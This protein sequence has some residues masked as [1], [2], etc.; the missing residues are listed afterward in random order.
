MP[1]AEMSLLDE[2][3]GAAPWEQDGALWPWLGRFLWSPALD[4]HPTRR[5]RLLPGWPPEVWSD[6]AVCAHI[7]RHLLRALDLLDTDP[8]GASLNRNSGGFVVALLPQAPLAR[9]A[10]YTG[11]ALRGPAVLDDGT[12]LNEDERSF[13]SQ[14]LPL[15]WH[16]PDAR[17]GVPENTPSGMPANPRSG[18]PGSPVSGAPESAASGTPENAG[19]QA[20]T[21]ILGPQ[22]EEITRRFEWKTPT[23]LGK[24]E[25]V[26]GADALLA[27]IGKLLKEF[28]APWSSLFATLRRPAHQIR[29]RG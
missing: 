17:A 23:G 7:S 15:Y 5:E 10:R 16:A 19:W 14:R 25:P 12:V 18:V 22:P 29:L 4:V 2:Q 3:A 24:A 21:A 27:L 6:P 1:D 28:E 8:A 20:L 11:L 26:A 13:V 9:L